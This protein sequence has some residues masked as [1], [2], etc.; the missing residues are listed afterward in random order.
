MKCIKK[1]LSVL[2]WIRWL[3]LRVTPQPWACYL[4]CCRSISVQHFRPTH[5]D[6]R[7]YETTERK[8]A[9]ERHV[10]CS[11]RSWPSDLV[12][13]H[14]MPILPSGKFPSALR[15]YVSVCA[16]ICGLRV[17]EGPPRNSARSVKC[18]TQNS[19]GLDGKKRRNYIQRS[20]L[21][22]HYVTVRNHL[23]TLFAY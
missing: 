6:R 7:I 20:S 18:E 8:T 9:E 1:V 16:L 21:L 19:Y 3:M 23:N 22:G 2:L 14:L 15:Q 13:Y 10:C 12:C 5:T 4:C 17:V 11:Y